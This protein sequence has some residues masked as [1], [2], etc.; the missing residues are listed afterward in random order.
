MEGQNT[1]LKGDNAN[2]L[3]ASVTD[4]QL[5]NHPSYALSLPP[6]TTDDDR[7]YPADSKETY[8]QNGAN[9]RPVFVQSP[10]N[11]VDVERGF[12]A[13]RLVNLI[14]PCARVYRSTKGRYGTV[15]AVAAFVA[16]LLVLVG[17]VGGITFG[18]IVSVEKGLTG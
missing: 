6:T 4:E 18:I 11:G 16:V 17:A 1:D 2:K 14:F 12:R 7:G 5:H 15:P 9:D 8:T 10:A 3:L 13:K